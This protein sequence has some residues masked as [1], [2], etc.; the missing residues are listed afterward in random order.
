MLVT[1]SAC[2]NSST[3]VPDG[4]YATYRPEENP[5][6]QIEEDIETYVESEN[7]YDEQSSLQTEDE[8]IAVYTGFEEYDD[9]FDGLR[10]VMRDGLWGYVDEDWEVIVP[11]MYNDRGAFSNGLAPVKQGYFWGVIDRH[12]N[13][14]VNFQFDSVYPFTNG[15]VP[16]RRPFTFNNGVLGVEVNQAVGVIDETG[17]FIVPLNQRYNHEG[18]MA[19]EQRGTVIPTNYPMRF[20]G[21]FFQLQYGWHDIF[22]LDG[23]FVRDHAN[24]LYTLENGNLLIETGRTRHAND[25]VVEYMVI[26]ATQVYSY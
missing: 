15:F 24:I 3:E 26:N 1:I 7:I 25:F 16:L 8:E 23:T 20:F 21:E 13:V 4:Y 17:N 6:K 2:G 11:F 19:F 18:R 10:A 14:I 12:N 5:S 9:I 22:R